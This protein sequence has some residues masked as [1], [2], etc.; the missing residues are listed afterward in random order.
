MAYT[1]SMNRLILPDI[2][3]AS[4]LYLAIYGMA[5]GDIIDVNRTDLPRGYGS[6]KTLVARITR[7]YKQFYA[8]NRLL[9]PAGWRIIRVNNLEN[10]YNVNIFKSK[11]K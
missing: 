10:S 3:N 2:K 1:P 4:A 9:N 8:I 6:V 5:E 7:S 11:N